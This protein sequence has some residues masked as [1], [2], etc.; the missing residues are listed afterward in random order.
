MKC[1]QPMAQV[2]SSCQ[3]NVK[4]LSVLIPPQAL[5]LGFLQQAGDDVVRLKARG[6]DTRE[7]FT[8]I[9]QLGTAPSAPAAL[10]LDDLRSRKNPS[11]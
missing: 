3:T 6:C 1:R 11:V 5:Q 4:E 9:K 7:E 8:L 10:G 2:H